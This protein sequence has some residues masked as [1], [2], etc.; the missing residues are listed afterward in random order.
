VPVLLPFRRR[1]DVETRGVNSLN[2]RQFLG[3]AALGAVAMSQLNSRAADTPAP[4]RKVKLGLIGSGWY[5]MVDVKAAFKAGGVEVVALCDVDSDN[6]AK[7]AA[8][9]EQ[10]Q[11]SKPRTFKLYEEMLAVPGLEAVIIGTP[12]HWH[13]LQLIAAVQRGLDV[14]SEKPLCYDVREGRAMVDAVAKSGRIVQVG[15][16][17]RQSPAYQQV[18]Q[19]INDGH[20]GRIVQA[21]VQINYTAG[22]LSP[23]PQTP[24]AALDWDLWSGPGPK[25]PYSPQ[26]GHKSWRLEKT[27]GQGHLYDWGIHLIDATR[28]MLG[29]TAPRTITATGGLYQL[30]GRI[31]TPDT[32][33]AH[34]EFERCPVT[35]RHRLWGAEEYT[36]DTNNGIFLYGEKGT[37]FVTDNRWVHIPKAKGA[38]RKVTEVKADLGTLHMANFLDCVR[39]R[40]P[41]ICTVAD[42]HLSTS[43]VKLAMI[44]YETGARLTWDAKTEQIVG[45]PAAAKLLKRD[46][47]APHK[48]P[49]Q[50]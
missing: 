28:L 19:F 4:G 32:L 15:F 9:V 6:L 14:Y 37:V 41:A 13:A 5:G 18:R 27:S 8:E 50:A 16:Q 33:V 7:G 17:R 29:E 3:T 38:E 20:L 24:P 23:E 44:A 11:G 30:K 22:L 47:R 48:H 39:S 2:R 26:V 45:N 46:Y 49:Y 35:W 25:I 42:A 36:P 10:L 40:Q 31:T 34:F 1:A 12:P 21:E 43:T